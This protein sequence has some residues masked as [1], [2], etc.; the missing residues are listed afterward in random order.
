MKGRDVRVLQV[1]EVSVLADYFIIV[2]ADSGRHAKAIANA[3]QQELKHFGSLPLGL[4][5]HGDAVWL[6]LDF[7]DVVVHIQLPDAREFYDLDHYWGDA[8]VIEL[9]AI[10]PV[11]LG[12]DRDRRL[13]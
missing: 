9:K 2:T 5:G 7:G 8:P 6:L 11:H 4:E 12:E 10:P 3:V 1:S 13:A